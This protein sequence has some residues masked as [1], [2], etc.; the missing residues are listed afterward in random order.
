MDFVRAYNLLG[1]DEKALNYLGKRFQ[2]D[3]D[4]S[5]VG[6]KTGTGNGQNAAVYLVKMP[7]STG[8]GDSTL[9]Y[10]CD[11]NDVNGNW[12]AEVDIMEANMGGWHVTPHTCSGERDGVTYTSTNCDRG[13]LSATYDGQ[14]DDT[15]TALY[16][17]DGH[18]D[19][20][21]GTAEFYVDFVESGGQWSEFNSQ[22]TAANGNF[23]T[24]SSGSGSDATDY[25]NSMTSA[26]PGMTIVLSRWGS[27]S[28]MDWLTGNGNCGDSDSS[29][30][31]AAS[32]PMTISNLSI[33][34]IPT[35]RASDIM[36]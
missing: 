29:I 10:Y 15:T 34:T 27:T 11:A 1:S 6:C 13:G 35:R 14:Y 30:V 19:M 28:D 4:I 24:T 36:V 16:G 25:L 2:Y 21:K 18:L 8:P 32:A 26:L 33:K 23:G 7:S 9:D 31:N 20:S 12:C 5:T 17:Y 3:V 22:L